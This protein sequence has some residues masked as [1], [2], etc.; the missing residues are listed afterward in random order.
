M[1]MNPTLQRLAAGAAVVVLIAAVEAAF[2]VARSDTEP[3]DPLEPGNAGAPAEL[4]QCGDCH[5]V[6]P[7]GCC[8]AVPGLR[9]YRRWTIIST[10]TLRSRRRPWT[11][12][13]I[14]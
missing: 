13:A 14:S 2:G 11:S 6:F 10:K 5:M 7:P 1:N 4:K 3:P 9:F 8:P 12:S